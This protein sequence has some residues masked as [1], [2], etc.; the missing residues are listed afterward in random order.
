MKRS[1]LTGTPNALMKYLHAVDAPELNHH[2]ENVVEKVADVLLDNAHKGGE[3]LEEVLPETRLPGAY[4]RQE[5]RHDL[6]GG[7]VFVSINTVVTRYWPQLG[8]A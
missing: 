1:E 2:F 6:L 8:S 7:V 3:G 4:H 5:W